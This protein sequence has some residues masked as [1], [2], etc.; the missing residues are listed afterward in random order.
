MKP[1]IFTADS[2]RPDKSMEVM[3]LRLVR[4][5]SKVWFIAI[6]IPITVKEVYIYVY[7]NN[8]FKQQF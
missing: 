6:D 5:M 8:K 4:L 7:Y 3:L 2:I 1:V